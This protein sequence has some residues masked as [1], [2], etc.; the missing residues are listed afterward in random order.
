MLVG[1]LLCSPQHPV[2][3][4]SDKAEETIK[5]PAEKLLPGPEVQG[6]WHKSPSV[7]LP[8]SSYPIT[9]GVSGWTAQGPWSG[10]LTLRG[11]MSPSTGSARRVGGTLILECPRRRGGGSQDPQAEGFQGHPEPRNPG[12]ICVVC[13]LSSIH[14]FQSCV[15][16]LAYVAPS[17]AT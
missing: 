8:F 11:M 15:H 17:P 6:S 7:T 4:G 14:P 12:I 10:F 3:Q 5:L 1:P 9:G 16:I 2:L 13:V